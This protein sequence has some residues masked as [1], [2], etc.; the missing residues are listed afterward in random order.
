MAA[1]TQCTTYV[2]RFEVATAR[3]LEVQYLNR[4]RGGGCKLARSY[5]EIIGRVG[6]GQMTRKVDGEWT[7][8]V[9][10]GERKRGKGG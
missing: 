3:Q 5:S 6:A 7:P 1:W 10:E 4:D 2:R 9:Y 8:V